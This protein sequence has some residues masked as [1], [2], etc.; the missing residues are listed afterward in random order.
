MKLTIRNW[1]KFQHYKDRN[2]P[3]VK[4]HVGL[5]EDFDF[6]C[7]PLASKALAPM[8]WLLASRAEDASIPADPAR[9]AFMLR[10][11]VEDVRA[12]L[13]ALIEKGFLE[14]DSSVLAERLQV[15]PPE[16]REQRYRDTEKQDQ[17]QAPQA[18]K[19]PRSRGAR[20][21]QDW[22]PSPADLD[23]IARERPDLDAQTVAASFR[24][25]WHAKAGKDACKTDWAATWRNWVRNQRTN[26]QTRAGPSQ[27]LQA[28][29]KAANRAAIERMM[30]EGSDVVP[31]G[32]RPRLGQLLG[33]RSGEP[34]RLG[35]AGP[36]DSDV[37]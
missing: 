20:L 13:S 22:T 18:A 24:D 3:W 31:S 26:P 9:L 25:F 2:P 15:A 6:Q 16:N 10:W 17:E 27:S 21:P 1:S 23:F 5:L 36:D 30:N 33:N 14:G 32:N 4:L 29:V 35:F 8:L 12:G 7:L 28:Q 11:P 19:E 37:D 34:A